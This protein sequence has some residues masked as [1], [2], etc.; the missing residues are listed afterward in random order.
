[1]QM[2][3]NSDS[4]VLVAAADLS[5]FASFPSSQ[6]NLCFNGFPFRFSIKSSAPTSDSFAVEKCL[7]ESKIKQ[8]KH[9]KFN[10]PE[11]LHS[12][13]VFSLEIIKSPSQLH[14][15]GWTVMSCSRTRNLRIK[16][17]N[18]HFHESRWWSAE[19]KSFSIACHGTF[20]YLLWLGGQMMIDKIAS[21]IFARLNVSLQT[22][23]HD[24]NIRS[25]P[26]RLPSHP[27]SDTEPEASF[28][29]RLHYN[30]FSIFLA[31]ATLFHSPPRLYVSAFLDNFHFH[32]MIQLGALLLMYVC[33]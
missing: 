14:L 12:F 28:R 20:D 23:T 32:P 11:Q 8:E 22:Q 16:T 4:I 10:S 15:R 2:G 21:M 7:V 13:V 33:T 1:M 31:L 29:I 27:S 5:C 25:L 19:S 9:Q 30:S 17:L 18:L 26:R 3:K 24:F 6:K